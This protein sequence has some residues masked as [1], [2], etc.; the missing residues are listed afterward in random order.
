MKIIKT[1]WKNKLHL[2]DL[3]IHFLEAVKN[4]GIQSKENMK[5]SYLKIQSRESIINMKEK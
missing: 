1:R 2:L 3:K 4:L 5:W